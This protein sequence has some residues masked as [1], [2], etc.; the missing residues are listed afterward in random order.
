LASITFSLVM[1]FRALLAALHSSNSYEL[2]VHRIK[3]RSWDL[4]PIPGRNGETKV[5][6]EKPSTGPLGIKI[7]LKYGSKLRTLSHTNFR[8]IVSNAES[9]LVA[10]STSRRLLQCVNL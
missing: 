3:M 1:Y 4:Q 9:A 8:P 5:R 10:W 7:A 2:S 6:T